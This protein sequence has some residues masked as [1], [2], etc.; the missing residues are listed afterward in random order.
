MTGDTLQQAYPNNSHKQDWAYYP[1]LGGRGGGPA[2]PTTNVTRYSFWVDFDPFDIKNLKMLSQNI[3]FQIFNDS[4]LT[5]PLVP[6]FVLDQSNDITDEI[7]EANLPIVPGSSV[8]VGSATIN[9][10]PFGFLDDGSRTLSAFQPP[11]SSAVAPPTNLAASPTNNAGTIYTSGLTIGQIYYY[12]ITATVGGVESIASSVV[13]A[14]PTVDLPTI[15]ITFNSVSNASYYSVY[16]NTVNSF[17]SGSLQLSSTYYSG[18]PPYYVN[19]A[20]ASQPVSSSFRNDQ[21]NWTF[22]G[23]KSFGSGFGAT[24]MVGQAFVPQQTKLTGFFL[25]DIFHTN[26]TDHTTFS[27][28]KFELWDTNH[29]FYAS[30]GTLQPTV[31]SVTSTAPTGLITNNLCTAFCNNITYN[32]GDDGSKYWTELN[33]VGV[34]LATAVS[35]APGAKYYIVVRLVTPTVSNYYAI[36]NNTDGTYRDNLY[37]YPY[38]EAI[39]ATDG[40]STFSTLVDANSKQITFPFITQGNVGRYAV[41]YWWATVGNGANNYWPGIPNSNDYAFLHIDYNQRI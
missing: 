7:I 27:A 36:G 19:T 14:I 5:S 34:Q 17:T 15:A 24:T 41:T 12:V 4:L 23:Y 35:V 38:G 1:W 22:S 30:L 28:V 16:R 9:Y 6:Y 13:S 39:T 3:S 26:T 32:T 2:N 37:Y 33:Q 20:F 40:S 21:G 11:S 18:Q 29:N 25:R 8:Q 10:P 31:T